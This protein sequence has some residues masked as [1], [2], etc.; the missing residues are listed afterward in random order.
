MGTVDYRKVIQLLKKSNSNDIFKSLYN[1]LD[2][3][4]QS[5]IQNEIKPKKTLSRIEKKK[6]EKLFNFLVLSTFE[7]KVKGYLE[8]I[9]EKVCPVYCRYRSA[10]RIINIIESLLDIQDPTL[11]FFI[12]KFVLRKNCNC[13]GRSSLQRVKMVRNSNS[14]L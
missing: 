4:E 9:K 10:N 14:R 13:S 8:D 7:E 1:S 11:I 12:I 3:E 5:S 2:S 6:N